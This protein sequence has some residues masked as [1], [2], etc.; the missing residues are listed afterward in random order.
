MSRVRSWTAAEV[1]RLSPDRARSLRTETQA[2]LRRHDLSISERQG[3]SELVRLLDRRLSA[4]DDVPTP[5]RVAEAR[6]A[7]GLDP[8]TSASHEQK[9]REAR[10]LLYNDADAK[11]GR[12]RRG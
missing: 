7:L 2:A 11:D 10:S 1:E 9:M 6:K 3:A 4:L 8:S 12:V 5:L